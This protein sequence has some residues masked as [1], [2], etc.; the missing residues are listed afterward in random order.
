MALPEAPKKR[1]RGSNVG[2]I[3][4]P[5]ETPS[6]EDN[7]K[8]DND[9]ILQERMDSNLVPEY[10]TAYAEKKDPEYLSA[11][12]RF[13]WRNLSFQ[14]T[15][16]GADLMGSIFNDDP[17]NHWNV[18][19][20]K[21]MLSEVQVNVPGV[22]TPYLYF[23][24]YK[25]TFAWHVE[26]M[27]LFS[28][29]YIHFGAPKVWYVVPPAERSKFERFASSLFY[30]EANECPEFLRHKNC[31]ISPS[32]VASKNIT[33][34]KLV[35]YQNEFVITFPAGILFIYQA[36]HQG[37][38]TDFNCAES[39]NF[40]T[41]AW[42][43][44]GRQ[45]NFCECV[46]DSVVL[47]VAGIFGEDDSVVVKLP[48]YLPPPPA[49]KKKTKTPVS[50]TTVGREKINV[51]QHILPKIRCALCPLG[52]S[53]EFPL[54]PTDKRGVWAHVECAAYIP[55][56]T[57]E[58]IIDETKD[59]AL[60]EDESSQSVPDVSSNATDHVNQIQS[61]EADNTAVKKVEPKVAPY[62]IRGIENICRDRWKLKCSVCQWEGPFRKDLGACIQCTKGKCV[63]AYHVTCAIKGGVLVELNDE[64]ELTTLCYTHDPFWIEDRKKMQK[65]QLV[66]DCK[67]KFHVGSLVVARF[68]GVNYEGVVLEILLDKE[69][70]SVQ[71][72]EQY[73]VTHI[74]EDA[75]FAPFESLKLKPAAKV[76]LKPKPVYTDT[77][78]RKKSA[79]K[80]FL[81]V[82]FNENL[83]LITK[84]TQSD[85][86]NQFTE[87]ITVETDFILN[88]SQSSPVTSGNELIL[89]TG[90][91]IN[92]VQT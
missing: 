19:T 51:V 40:A 37:F 64:G 87:Q 38:N 61:E 14:N 3:D 23:G 43:P 36:Y 22:T 12:E 82:V 9:G 79:M 69:G 46:H 11:L 89:G 8:I 28:I 35:Q 90:L 70:C 65:E 92:H 31:V 63:R 66:A 27:D 20:L 41:P 6:S 72:E 44:F 47:D 71:F 84:D 24:M 68:E 88:S 26:D 75:V 7:A 25:A 91:M 48:R 49:T 13:Y 42:I 21:S 74:R 15:M 5:C 77:K 34:H 57:V 30:D 52:D 53:E 2:P 1:K 85:I 67:D 83:G 29:N 55:E 73:F 4:S 60:G 86:P 17:N 32:V 33:V 62:R 58:E 78:P 50:K 56:T 76:K 16:Y 45:A 54:M 18:S 10:M 59:S 81:S 80:E 39:I